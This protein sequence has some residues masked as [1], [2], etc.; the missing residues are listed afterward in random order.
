MDFYE[1]EICFKTVLEVSFYQKIFEVGQLHICLET[2][3]NCPKLA[4]FGKNQTD[5]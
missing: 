3:K 2:L 1:A 4:I 5:F